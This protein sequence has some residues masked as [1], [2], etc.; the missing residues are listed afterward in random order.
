MWSCCAVGSGN[1]ATVTVLVC[2][3]PRRSF[4]GTRCHLCPPGSPANARST[5]RPVTRST[6]KPALASRTSCSKALQRDVAAIQAVLL[7]DEELRVVA[8][9]GGAHFDDVGVHWGLLSSL[10]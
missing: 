4:G 6:T 7:E 1:T 10:F 8:S 3:R 5:L 9:F 2:T